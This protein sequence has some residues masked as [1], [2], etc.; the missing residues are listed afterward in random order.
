M[1]P[2]Q[3]VVQLIQMALHHDER[4]EIVHTGLVAEAPE[5]GGPFDY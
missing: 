4:V 5:P 1:S 3:Q 2:V